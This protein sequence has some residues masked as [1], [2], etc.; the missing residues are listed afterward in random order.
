MEISFR[1][2]TVCMM[3]LSTEVIHRVSNGVGALLDAAEDHGLIQT[4]T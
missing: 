3:M 1:Q 4:D 2:P